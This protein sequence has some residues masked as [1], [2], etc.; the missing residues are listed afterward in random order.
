MVVLLLGGDERLLLGFMRAILLYTVL[1]DR[2]W[3]IYLRSFVLFL[4]VFCSFLVFFFVFFFSLSLFFSSLVIFYFGFV[5]F[6]LL[7]FLQHTNNRCFVSLLLLM[8]FLP[9]LPTSEGD[10]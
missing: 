5:F 8:S 9:F 6:S 1:R 7:L 10:G 3:D 4:F 2:V